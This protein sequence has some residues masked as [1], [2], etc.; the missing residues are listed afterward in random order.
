MI[1]VTKLDGRTIQLNAEWIQTVEATPDTLVTLTNG[2]TFFVKETVDQVV[3]AFK[4]YKKE[5]IQLRV[6]EG[7]S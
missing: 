3:A 2:Q 5:L 1:G 4:Q 7:R 6:I